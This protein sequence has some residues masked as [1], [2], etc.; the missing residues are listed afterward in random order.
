MNKTI[1][2]TSTAAGL[3]CL[4]AQAAIVN[5]NLTG[6]KEYDGWDRL[7]SSAPGLTT[8]TLSTG[9]GFGSNEAGSGDAMLLRVSGGHYP[10]SLG[11]YSFGSNSTL[12]VSD[13]V[14]SFS[15]IRTVAITIVSWSNGDEGLPSGSFSSLPTLGFNGGSQALAADWFGTTRV[16]SVDFGG[17]IQTYAFTFQW[18]LGSFGDP[19]TS[20]D[21]SWGQIVHTGVLGIQLESADT[22]SLSNAVPE[23]SSA[24]LAASAAI[25]AFRRKRR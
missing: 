25:L 12:R 1:I 2:L 19:I 22:Y 7:G 20:Y 8:T 11:L 23:P 15:D 17:P 9:S 6:N 13:T 21:V 24:L 4:G 16:G 3:L 5:N 14:T 10:A 18:D